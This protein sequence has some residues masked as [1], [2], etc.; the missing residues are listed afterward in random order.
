MDSS[1]QWTLNGGQLTLSSSVSLPR[2]L[3]DATQQDSG[4]YVLGSVSDSNNEEQSIVLMSYTPLTYVCG[5]SFYYQTNHNMRLRLETSNY[6]NQSLIWDSPIGD[7]SSQWTPVNIPIGEFPLSLST[8]GSL[9]VAMEMIGTP[10]P[11]LSYVAVDEVS[12]HF[13]LP[14]NYTNLTQGWR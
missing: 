13:C 3:T 2:P 5:I 6:G 4:V 11:V 1:C 12:L 14:C 10:S 8:T 7:H 9:R